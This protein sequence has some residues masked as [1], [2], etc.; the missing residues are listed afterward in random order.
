MKTETLQVSL[1]RGVKLTAVVQQSSAPKYVTTCEHC[2]LF[3]RGKVMLPTGTGET[4]S[5]GPLDRAG[6]D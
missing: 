4:Q 5:D 6:A 2:K 3:V 1:G